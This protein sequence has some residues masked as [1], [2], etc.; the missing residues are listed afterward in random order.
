MCPYGEGRHTYMAEKSPKTN[1]KNSLWNDLEAS[2]PHQIS[3]SVHPCGCLPG[4]KICIAQ[5]LGLGRG[6]AECPFIW[7]GHRLRV[8]E[9]HSS[10]LP[11]GCMAW[12]QSAA[13]GGQVGGGKGKWLPSPPQTS[14]TP[15]QKFLEA[16]S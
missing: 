15:L 12:S 1:Y 3:T 13:A 14:R 11:A 7:R 4:T 6:G 2:W 5:G 10:H 9:L 16:R 8:L